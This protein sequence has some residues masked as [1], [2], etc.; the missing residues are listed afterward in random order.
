M[1]N[2]VYKVASEYLGLKEYPGAKHN[3][4]VVKMFADSGHS[5]VKDDETPWCAAFVG[6]VLAECGIK[7]TGALDARSYMKW[8]EPVDLNA[9]QKG[10]VVVFWRGSKSGWQGHV[11]FFDRAEGNEIYVLGGNQGNTVSV[12]PYS[13]DRL[14]GVRRHH[15]ERKKPGQTQTV[16][17]SVTGAVS[18]VAAGATAV[19][20]LDGYAQLAVVALLAVTLITFAVVFRA[21]IKAWAA[22]V[23]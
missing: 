3:A 9:A 6:S 20:A 8:G 21:R 2:P 17:A 12:A 4:E 13:R 15:T 5:W 19:G 1:M 7:G 23:K 16:K 14:L 10:D 18:T 11:A 22:G